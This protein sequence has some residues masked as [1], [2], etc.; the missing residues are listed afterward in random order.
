MVVDCCC[1]KVVAADS[2]LSDLIMFCWSGRLA[3]K[4]VEQK[5]WLSRVVPD[6]GCY[7]GFEILVLYLISRVGMLDLFFLLT[8]S[9][10][11][12]GIRLQGRG[13]DRALKYTN[14]FFDRRRS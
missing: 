6:F 5:L 11:T 14:T 4:L 12:T 8:N 3:H 9:D 13:L 7:T 10:P 1:W 2:G